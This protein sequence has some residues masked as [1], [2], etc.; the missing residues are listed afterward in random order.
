MVPVAS[1]NS[2]AESPKPVVALC[3]FGCGAA[4]KSSQTGGRDRLVVA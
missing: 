1:S 2:H 3:R 4:A